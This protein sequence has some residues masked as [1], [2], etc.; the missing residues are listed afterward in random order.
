MSSAK[1]KVQTTLYRVACT[2]A[3]YVCSPREGVPKPIKS[4]HRNVQKGRTI[5]NKHNY[6]TNDQAQLD[7][8]EPTPH[9]CDICIVWNRHMLATPHR[10]YTGEVYIINPNLIHLYLNYKRHNAGWVKMPG[11]HY[12]TRQSIYHS[13][14]LEELHAGM[15]RDLEEDGI[16]LYAVLSRAKL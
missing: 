3:R 9:L 11:S 8:P 16:N 5:S 15:V 4:Q 10:L 6:L 1:R 2:D 13:S 14:S 7:M 12:F